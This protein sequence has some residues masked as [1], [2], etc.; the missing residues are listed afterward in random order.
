MTLSQIIDGVLAAQGPGQTDIRVVFQERPNVG[1]P[2]TSWLS[3]AQINFIEVILAAEVNANAQ[4]CSN[5]SVPSVTIT[6]NGGTIVLAETFTATSDDEGV[7]T[8]TMTVTTDGFALPCAQGV[9]FQ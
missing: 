1:N 8:V 2:G 7:V 3:K 5:F 6:A 4:G 9:T